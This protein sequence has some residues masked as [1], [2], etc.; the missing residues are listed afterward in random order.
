MCFCLRARAGYRVPSAL[1]VSDDASIDLF[2]SEL[3][4][5][6]EWCRL[7]SCVSGGDVHAVLLCFGVDGMWG[8][9]AGSSD[10]TRVATPAI[11]AF[12]K[13]QKGTGKGEVC[14]RGGC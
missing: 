10:E 11:P 7:I 14:W 1:S 6:S 12:P 9:A 4:C 5:K 3:A 13:F 8:K 2:I